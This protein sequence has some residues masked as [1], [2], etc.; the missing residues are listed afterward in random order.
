M[1]WFII[2]IVVVVFGLAYLGWVVFRHLPD[3]KSIDVSSIPQ[4]KTARVKEK[5]VNEKIKRHKIVAKEK[6]SQFLTPKKE[7]FSRQLEKIKNR[8]VELEAKYHPKFKNAGQ[9]TV[10]EIFSA[11]EEMLA[12]GDYGLA[13]KKLIEVISRDRKNVAAYEMLGDIY[14][15]LKSYDQAAEIYLHLIKLASSRSTAAKNL[16]AISRRDDPAGEIEFLSSLDVNPRLA[17]YYANLG[18]AYQL[19][20]KLDWALDCLLK[21]NSV[22][23]NNPKYLDKLIGLSVAMKDK[24]LARKTL[25]HLKKINPENA[26]IEEWQEEVEKIE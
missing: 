26:K 19:M 10:P 17:V 1:L 7:Y 15:E 23:S 2:T 11:A 12:N 20:D 25:N 3:L 13:E 16:S 21:A 24:G 14:F 4:E 22:D 5:I 6:F 9:Q 8:A 18:E